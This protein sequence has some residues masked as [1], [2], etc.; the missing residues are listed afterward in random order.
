MSKK[1][2]NILIVLHAIYV[3]TLLYGFYWSIKGHNSSGLLMSF[4]G[5]ITPLL[6]PVSL[7][8]FKLKP[9]FEIYLINII[10]VYIASLVGSVFGGY[11]IPFFD[12]LLHFSSG[13]F[14][15]LLAFMIFSYLKKTPCVEEKNERIISLIFINAVNMMIA[16]F[17]E[18]FEFAMLV[19]FNNDGINHYT[20]GVYDS[21]TDMLVCFVGGLIITFYV[22]HWYHSGKE[23]FWIKL[24]K[25]FFE[26]NFKQGNSTK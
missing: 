25:N 11:S 9:I 10:F 3:I 5:I 7:K 20:T 17:W 13:L 19:F 24:N 23:N 1:E 8:I 26:L 6:V 2:K 14:L 18:F 4:V 22:M 15:S 12:K 21:M 16:V